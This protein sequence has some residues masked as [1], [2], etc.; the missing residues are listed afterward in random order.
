MNASPVA[1]D[2]HDEPMGCL[3]ALAVFGERLA[4]KTYLAMAAL[5]PRHAG[6]LRR[7]AQMEAGHAA[8]FVRVSRNHGLVLGADFAAAR[9]SYLEEQIER[10]REAG[11]FDALAVLQGLIVESLAIATYEPFLAIADRYPGAGEV[12]AAALADEREHVDWMTGYLLARFADTPAALAAL[13]EEVNQSGV[14][15]VGGTLV[16]IGGYL[17]AAGLPASQCASAMI[18]GYAGLLA[19]S[20]MSEDAAL[21][22]V[23]RSFLPLLRRYQAARRARA[24]GADA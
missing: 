4:A 11:R 21:R 16:D 10:Y 7:F 5:E 19:R 12:F 22:E 14:D 6:T 20:G 3:M 2:A 9:L 1:R 15:C 18:D 24:G 23:V 13:A 8:S 17:E